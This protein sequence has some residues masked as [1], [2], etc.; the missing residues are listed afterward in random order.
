MRRALTLARRG[1][2]RVEPNPMVG[3][4]IVRGGRVLGAGFHRRFGGAHAEVEALRACRRNPRGATAYV[5]LEP[6][7]H[8]GKTPPCVNALIEAGIAEVVI[9][10]L[11]PNPKVSGGGVRRLR[12]AGVAVR[13]GVLADETAR[14]LAPFL[15]RVHSRRPYI[16]AKWAQSLNGTLIAP[17]GESRWISCAT[18][19]RRVHRLRGRV[20]AVI[21]GIGTVIADDPLLNARE[22]PV[23][24]LATRVVLDTRLRTP[25]HSKLTATARSVPT[26]VF[27]TRDAAE[28][29][30]ASSLRKHGVEVI[31]VT[32]AS[33]KL[34]LRAVLATLAGRGMTNVLVEGGPRALSSFLRA[35]LVDEAMV[36]VAPRLMGGTRG[37]VLSG[38]TTRLKFESARRCGVD[39]LYH[40]RRVP[41]A[42]TRSPARRVR[43]RPGDDAP[44]SV[45][46][47]G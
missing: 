28:G 26:L 1:E 13:I 41:T 31:G 21:V 45:A 29:R 12:A 33:G 15:T 22:V 27:T 23:K 36:F 4:V 14:V 32:S 11:D 35:D 42:V 17:P 2:G 8:F 6:C 20:D 3:C 47:S 7:C 18:S 34:K 39:V 37:G 43:R 10:M 16:I 38:S 5:T 40:G 19:L 9:P 30:R 46:S 25:V 44:S 24:R